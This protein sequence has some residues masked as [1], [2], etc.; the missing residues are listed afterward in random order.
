MLFRVWKKSSKI[1]IV[2]SFAFSNLVIVLSVLSMFF[3]ILKGPLNFLPIAILAFL[4]LPL[5]IFPLVFEISR[6]TIRS[7][8]KP[9]GECAKISDRMVRE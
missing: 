6:A 5:L 7:A 4:V 2:L 9:D 8:H 3:P 1:M